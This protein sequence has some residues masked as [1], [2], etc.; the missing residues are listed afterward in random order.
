MEL[1]DSKYVGASIKAK[2]E[3]LYKMCH[4]YL[5]ENFYKFSEANKIKI[6]LVLSSKMAPQQIEGSYSVTKLDKIKINDKEL[7]F[8]I[9]SRIGQLTEHT[10][11][12]PSA[13][14]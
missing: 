14:N 7:E 8:N 13:D 3:Q 11:Q 12:A 1:S 6:A 4:E 2:Q 5:I 9:G 10:S